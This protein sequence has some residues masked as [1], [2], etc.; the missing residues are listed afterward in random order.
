[1]CLH[2]KNCCHKN[3]QNFLVDLIYIHT[4][5][6]RLKKYPLQVRHK[7]DWGRGFILLLPQAAVLPESDAG[8]DAS[9]EFCHPKLSDLMLHVVHDV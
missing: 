5:I 1:M 9:I 2:V 3:G 6:H 4:Y 7:W 8:S